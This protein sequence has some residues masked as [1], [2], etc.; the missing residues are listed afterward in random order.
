MGWGLKIGFF[1]V[2]LAFAAFGGWIIAIPLFVLLFLPPILNRRSKEKRGPKDQPVREG[3]TSVLSVVGAVLVLLSAVA[4]FS[5]GTLSPIVFAICGF[6]LLLRG[7]VSFPT[8]TWVAPVKDSILLR[9]RLAPFRWTVLAEAKV[10]TRDL[11]GAM[12][13][14]S[15]RLLFTSGPKPKLFLV[16]TTSSLGRSGAE[17]TLIKQIQRSARSL[18]PLGV[19]LLPLDSA[20]AASI[21]TIHAPKAEPETSNLREHISTSDYSALVVEARHG[22]VEK[23][24][25][26]DQPDE[27]SRGS[28]VLSSLKA[29]NSGQLTLRELLRGAREKLGSPHPDRYSAFLSSMAATEGEALGQRVTETVE[30]GQQQLLLVASVGNPPVELSRAQLRAVSEIYE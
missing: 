3:G 26:Y 5:G 20:D 21:V 30:G 2:A 18:V 6:A 1:F 29:V 19:Y 13:G 11:E 17:R 10:S 25:L 27:G 28:S 12:S 14:V 23:F 9:H 24:D 4:F 7:R 16:Y 22:F 8:S 15:E